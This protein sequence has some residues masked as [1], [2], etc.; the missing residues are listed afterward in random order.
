MHAICH[1]IVA[2]IGNI[3]YICSMKIEANCKIN[4]GLNVLRRRADGFHDLETVMMPVCGLFDIVEVERTDV[5][6]VELVVR[7]IVV[8]CPP[9][10]NLCVK[11]Y[12]LMRERYGIGGVRI[13]LDKRVPF[14]AGLGGGSSD[15]T[16][17]LLALNEEFALSLSEKE[18]IAL[19]SELGSDTAFFVRNTPQLCTG[20]GEVMTPINLPIAGMYLMVAKPEES[21]STGE[22]YG[23]VRPAESATSLAELVQR[24]VEEWQAKVKNDFEPHVFVA[25]PAI[26]AIKETMLAAGAAYCSMSGSGSAVFGLFDK[27]PNIAFDE[28]IFTYIEKL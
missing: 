23:G 1:S 18:L 3:Q 27:M 12:R 25:H 6:D 19:A 17:V 10:K 21:V 8:D 28:K 4:I 14:G 22:A 24:P 2:I 16:A 9:E 20:R 15:A 5:D 11:A 13:T 26:A 7:G